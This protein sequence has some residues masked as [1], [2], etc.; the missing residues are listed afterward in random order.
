MKIREEIKSKLYIKQW[1]IG[2]AKG[3]FS[4][5]LKKGH[6]GLQYKW[7]SPKEKTRLFADPF[8]FDG[9][10]ND[11]KIIYE[12]LC[13][14]EGFGK[15]SVT[16][17]DRNLNVLSSSVVLNTGKHISYPKTLYMDNKLL[18]I[19][20]S[21]A[22]NQLISYEYDFNKNKLINKVALIEKKEL[23]DST[24]LYHENKY[25]LFATHLGNNSNSELYIYYS[26]SLY[27]PYEEHQLNPVKKSLNGSRPAGNFIKFNHCVYRPAQNNE[28]YYGKSITLFKINKL[29]ENEF[30]EEEI[31]EIKPPVN[32]AFSHGIHTIN[33]LNEIIVIDGLRIIFSPI[34]KINI[35]LNKIKKLMFARKHKD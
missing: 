7:I 4:D 21:S 34:D 25:W 17:I 22:S 5:F 33:F 32:S 18:V 23:L 30:S 6:T 1:S 9:K 10:D 8:I 20:E 16:N 26:R 15:L 29:T 3:S 31:I 24:I 27:G 12:D 28:E 2:V 19:P 35:Y 11:Y 14:I 13:L